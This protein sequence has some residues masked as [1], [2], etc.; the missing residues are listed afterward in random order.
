MIKNKIVL[1]TIIILLSF[2]SCSPLKEGELTIEQKKDSCII[3]ADNGTTV[4][5]GQVQYPIIKIKGRN[6]VSEKINNDIRALVNEILKPEYDYKKEYNDYKNS[7]ADYFS[8]AS[9]TMSFYVTMLDDEYISIQT[10]KYCHEACS[11]RDIEDINGITFSVITGEKA[12]FSNFCSNKKTLSE[13]VCKQLELSEKRGNISDFSPEDAK[14][15]IENNNFGWYLTDNH[16]AILFSPGE[17]APIMSGTLEA[18]IKM[19]DL[20]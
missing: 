19:S 2:C 4:Y 16:I 11:V 10:V 6:N 15:L 1:L 5:E 13:K 8:G 12:E 9:Y 7:G 17:A 20:N 3:N 18:D 14:Q